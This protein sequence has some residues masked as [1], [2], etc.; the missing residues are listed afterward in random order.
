L[1]KVSEVPMATVPPPPLVTVTCCELLVL[2]PP[3]SVTVRVTV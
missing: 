3:L 1:V 2:A